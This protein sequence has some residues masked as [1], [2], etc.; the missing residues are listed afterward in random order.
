ML[1]VRE[2]PASAY[3]R[4]AFDVRV[5]GAGPAEL[6]HLCLDQVGESLAHALRGH[7]LADNTARAAGLTR[8]HAALLALEMG[9]DENAPLAGALLQ[10]FRAARAEILGAVT[11]F[12]PDRLE[13]VRDDFAEIAAAL[14]PG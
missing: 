6:V 13:R 8:A 2:S 7:R 1:A 14:R 5:R 12:A 3:R 11:A 10:V 9:V 4:A